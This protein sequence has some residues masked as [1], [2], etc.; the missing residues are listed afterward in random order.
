MN[1]RKTITGLTLTTDQRLTVQPFL[2]MAATAFLAFQLR[3]SKPRKHTETQMTARF[4]TFHGG[5]WD[6]VFVLKNIM[7]PFNILK[8]EVT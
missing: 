4:P 5:L 3:N 2:K 8:T 1:T 6:F 7:A